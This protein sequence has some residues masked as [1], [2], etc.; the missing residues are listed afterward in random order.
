MTVHHRQ[1]REQ[2]AAVDGSTSAPRATEATVTAALSSD[3]PRLL[4]AVRPRVE[5]LAF[6][7]RRFHTCPVDSKVHGDVGQQL[8]QARVDLANHL[9]LF[10]S[11]TPLETA[12]IIL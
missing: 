5:K 4:F 7:Q 3:S 6:H 9:G 10:Q 8:W 11:G 2:D 1:R 12:H